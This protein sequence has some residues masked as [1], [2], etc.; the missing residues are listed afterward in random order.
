MYF[1]MF[2]EDRAIIKMG[3][4]IHPSVRAEQHSYNGNRFVR[5]RTGKLLLAVP[6][7]YYN[8]NRY[9]D[10]TRDA[11][12]ETPGFKRAPSCKDTFFVDLR[13]AREVAITIKKTY[14]ALIIE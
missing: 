5:G 3:Q 1:G 2:D 4:S 12:D 6:V 11:W 9:E 13:V 10:K 7:S 8:Q 14:S